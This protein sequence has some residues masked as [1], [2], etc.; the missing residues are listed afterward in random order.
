MATSLKGNKIAILVTDDFE[1]VELNS[2]RQALEDAGAEVDIVSDQAGEV[3][4]MN[5]DEKADRFEVDRTLDTADALD[6]DGVM[7]PGVVNGDA[8]RTVEKAQAFVKA[9]SREAGLEHQPGMLAQGVEAD[10]RPLVLRD[11][12]FGNMRR[13]VGRRIDRIMCDARCVEVDEALQLALA[14][15]RSFGRDPAREPMTRADQARFHAVL[16]LEPVKDD[17]ELQLPDRTQ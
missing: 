6:Y 12:Q 11:A 16:M 10:L 7:L 8:L 5:H 3:Q 17:F 13:H 1:Q 15:G 9:S 4:G 14:L 2:P